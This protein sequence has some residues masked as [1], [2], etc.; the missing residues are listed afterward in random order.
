MKAPNI[1]FQPPE[2]LQIPLPNEIAV[3]RWS[4]L[5]LGICDFFG[6]WDLEFGAF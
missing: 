5:G 6:V 2:E 3:Q 1:K 4:P